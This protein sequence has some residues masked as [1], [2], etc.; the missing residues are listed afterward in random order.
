[1]QIIILLLGIVTLFLIAL[2]L[3]ENRSAINIRTVLGAFVIQASIA[4]FVLY[5][6]FGQAFLL[7][8]S[9][10][11]SGIL[12]YSSEGINFLFGDI[13]RFKSGF[14]FA[15]HVLPV[16]IFV[17]SLVSVLYYFGIMQ[18]IVSLIGLIFEKL[19]T[20]SK[21]ESMAA[22][23][24]IFVGNSDVFILMRPYVSSMTRSELFALMTGG[25]ASI[26]GAVLVGYASMGIEIKYLLAAAFMS[27]PGGLLMAKLIYPETEQPQKITKFEHY[28]E[29]DKP[30]NFIEA[31]TRGA[32]NGLM[33]ALNV[34]A[35]LLALIA[36]IAAFDGLLGWS[37]SL[38]GMDDISLELIFS[39]I[40][41]PF[42]FLLGVP[43]SEILNVGGLIG[44]KLVL[45]EFVAYANYID[46]KASLSEHSQ[47]VTTIALAGFANFSAPAVLIGVLG[48]MV[49][50]KKSFIAMI[51]WKVI[52]AG[53][54]SNLMSAAL[55]GLFFAISNLF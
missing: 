29:E 13:G 6:P 34:G 20:T 51:G 18:K 30:I 2:L 16:I 9:N 12:E 44:Q 52:A 27:A 41:A 10:V 31:A 49:P 43:D 50:D 17:S 37:T 8:I 33:L 5:A 23:S 22:T 3:S 35:M 25:V 11:V 4:A 36:L 19:L 40:F 1:M 39:Y 53:L 15:I 42:A 24:N 32:S 26:A 28:D 14:I 48:T 55:A 7:S 47:V 38:L 45:N 21:A 54:L 46:I